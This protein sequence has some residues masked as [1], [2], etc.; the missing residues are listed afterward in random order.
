MTYTH[1]SNF[2]FD[3][4]SSF[5]TSPIVFECLISFCV[6]VWSDHLRHK[7][8]MDSKLVLLTTKKILNCQED[9]ELNLLV[10]KLTQP[11]N[12]FFAK[13]ITSISSK[14]AHLQ[15][16]SPNQIWAAELFSSISYL[17]PQ[18]VKHPILSFLAKV[19]FSPSSYQV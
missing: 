13:L 11:D 15:P 9:P 19:S 17:T 18:A 6:L 3:M 16:P 7:Q 2:H 10:N 5:P 12:K 4:I 8:V 1:F 14:L